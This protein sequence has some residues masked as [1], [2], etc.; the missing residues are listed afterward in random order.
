MERTPENNPSS[1]KPSQNELDLGFNQVE[2]ITPKKVVKPEPSLFNKA[3]SIFAKKEAVEPNHFAVRK[4]PTFGES[5]DNAKIENTT[6]STIAEKVKTVSAT[7]TS[8]TS[9]SIENM[10][11]DINT[12]T[13]SFNAQDVQAEPQVETSSKDTTDT[14]VKSKMKKPEDWAVMQKLPRKHR[15]LAIALICVVILLLALLW[16]KP[17]SDTV[18]DFQTDNNKNL[19]IEFQPLDQSQAIENVDV[20]NTAPTTEAVEQANAT[21]ENALSVPAPT[22]PNLQSESVATEAAKA[23]TTDTTKVAEQAK[24]IEKVKAVDTPKATEKPR[25]VEQVKAKPAEKT[26]ATE[27]VSVAENKPVKPAPKKPSVTDAKPATVSAAGSA[28]K[29][30]VIP[31]GTSLMQVFR[32]NNLN[33]SDVNAMTKANGAGGALSNFKPGDKVQVSLNA[34]GRVKTMR[35]ANGATFT[36][37][38]DG[39]YQYSK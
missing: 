22:T 38:A 18:E 5:A 14:E 4:E 24:P 1:E 16:L 23:E 8:A 30:L 20:N 9:A 26:K 27:K 39:T 34:Q 31:Q 17:S 2:P 12:S 25:A 33:I 7:A 13:E 19:P 28:S 10:N 15:R 37:Q 35:L 3:K 11:S 6:E 36:R 32:D 21:A 29:T